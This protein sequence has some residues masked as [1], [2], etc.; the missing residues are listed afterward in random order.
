MVGLIQATG[1]TGVDQ[2]GHP[3]GGSGRL[4]ALFA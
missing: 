4:D 3:G 2:F 1:V